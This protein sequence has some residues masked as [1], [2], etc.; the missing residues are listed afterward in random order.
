MEKTGRILHRQWDR[1]DT[2]EV[3]YQP[4]RLNAAE[5]KAGYDRAYR[6][7]YS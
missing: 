4:A 7:F 6:D 1:Y 2:R 5:L 3:V